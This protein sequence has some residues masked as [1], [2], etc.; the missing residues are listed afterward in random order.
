MAKTS[1]SDVI[2]PEIFAAYVIKQ[3]KE[4]SAL[5]QS[6]IAVQNDKLDDL[7]TQGGKLIICRSGRR[8]PGTM[9]CCPTAP[10]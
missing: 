4:L 8:L 6:G 7:V 2:V 10:R 5:I 1:I 3:T 9:R